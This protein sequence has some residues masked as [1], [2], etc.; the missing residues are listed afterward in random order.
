MEDAFKINKSKSYKSAG[1][2]DIVL[3]TGYTANSCAPVLLNIGFEHGNA[4]SLAA[5]R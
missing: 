2:V 3:T 5:S 1:L 4:L